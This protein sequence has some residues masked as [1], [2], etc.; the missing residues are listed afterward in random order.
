MMVRTDQLL[1]ITEAPGS[2][3]HWQGSAAETD[4]R[5]KKLVQLLKQYHAQFYHFYEKGSTRAMI[6]LQGLHSNDTFQ[7]SNVA[8]RMGL[9]LFCP[10]C[11]KLGGNTET[12]TTHLREVHYRLA[13]AYDI[14]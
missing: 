1:C 13:I 3:F 8:V 2:K 14:C 9:K 5:A 7:G 10:W 6:G 12:M 4:S 11:F